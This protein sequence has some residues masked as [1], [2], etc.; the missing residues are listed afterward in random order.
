MRVFKN[1]SFSHFANKEAISDRELCKAVRDAEQKRIH[2]G[3]KVIK[4]RLARAGQGKSG[5]YRIIMLF[6]RAKRA[7]FVYGFAKN[8]QDNIWRKE[9]KAL[10]KLAKVLLVLDDNALARA[11][12]EGE[13][14][15]V[16]CN[17]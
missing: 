17:E 2:L 10:Q 15:E 14:T 4:Q 12:N 5:G 13:I 11:M 6:Q 3:G 16:I 8:N 7:F 9:K 1:K